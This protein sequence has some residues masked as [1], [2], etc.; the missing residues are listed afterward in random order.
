MEQTALYRTIWRWHFYAGLL[1]MPLIL[2][3]SLTGAA[4]LF[5]PQ[6]DRW[7]ERDFGGLSAAG[8]VSPAAQVNAALAAW[9]KARFDAY[10]LPEAEGD[11]AAITLAPAD[12]GAPREVFVSPQGDVLGGFD[13]ERRITPMLARF[14]GSLMLGSFGDW[15]VELA[16][17]WAIVMILSG[18]YLWWP[19]DRR[20]AGVLWPRLSLGG[21]GF[22]RDLHAV[23]GFWVA[24]LAL[25][26]LATG[27]PWAGV[28]GS[29][30]A[31]V[32]TELGLV[33]GVQDW[34][35]GGGENAAAHHHG[36]MGMAMPMPI[37]GNAPLPFDPAMF[38]LAVAEAKGEH[39]AFPASVLPPGAP[40]RF[41]PPTGQV[42]TAKSEAQDRPLQRSVTYDLASGREIAREGFAD[43]HPI[44]RF[45]NYGIAWHEGQLLG[46]FNQL[47]GV[48]TAAL[49]VVLTVSGFAMWRKRRPAGSGLGAPPPPARKITRSGI[50]IS[51]V[52]LAALLPLFA[53][54]LAVFW[55]VERLALRRIRPVANWLGLSFPG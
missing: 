7:E 5:K 42:W 19:K 2:I 41:G 53:L 46:W 33:K 37:A 31:S 47:V 45:I 25:L 3:L 36:S 44:D 6:I 15:I 4:Y 1:V 35:I 39:L 27:L 34:K 55:L 29:A 11:A 50:V 16:A 49:L 24:G 8:A 13:P 14:H 52:A 43:K 32:R 9:P 51:G 10:R 12:G 22:W 28:W 21:R 17:S 18:L 26:M 23:V 54:S 40:Q 38:S 20:L 30:L 48:L